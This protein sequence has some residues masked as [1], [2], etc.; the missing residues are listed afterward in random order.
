MS[1]VTSVFDEVSNIMEQLFPCY[2]YD[3]NEE[4]KTR[5]IIL[6]QD[7]PRLGPRESRRLLGEGLENA[8]CWL[9]SL[10]V[11]S[12]AASVEAF[13]L[14]LVKQPNVQLLVDE[15]EA[16]FKHVCAPPSGTSMSRGMR[17]TAAQVLSCPDSLGRCTVTRGNVVATRISPRIIEFGH[18]EDLKMLLAAKTDEL[19]LG[20]RHETFHMLSSFKKMCDPL[21][22]QCLAG[23]AGYGPRRLP[24]RMG[25][26]IQAS[27]VPIWSYTS[28]A[29]GAPRTSTSCAVDSK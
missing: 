6:V 28:K 25:V 9:P 7:T 4:K 11:A 3:Y 5:S 19:N 26:E 29:H 14:D 22:E 17:Q 15:V 16:F 20:G 18:P 10:P 2:R 8:A 1:S 27:C 21:V 12:N 13:E 23:Q 24:H